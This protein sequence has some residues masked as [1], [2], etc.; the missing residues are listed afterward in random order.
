MAGN[1]TQHALSVKQTPA[2]VAGEVWKNGKIDMK[3]GERQRPK[4]ARRSS[5]RGTTVG[6]PAFIWQWSLGR[7]GRAENKNVWHHFVVA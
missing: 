2:F 3:D 6:Y 1:Y 7:R 5:E 4:S